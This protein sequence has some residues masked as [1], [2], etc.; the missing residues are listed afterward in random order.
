MRD[1][2]SALGLSTRLPKAHPLE[3]SEE[4]QIRDGKWDFPKIVRDE[5]LSESARIYFSAVA[6]LSDAEIGEGVILPAPSKSVP[7]VNGAVEAVSKKTGHRFMWRKA[8]RD[9]EE[10]NFWQRV[11]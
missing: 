7:L 10:V 8:D 6:M 11:R 5:P 9:G 1:I 3:T 4:G 2:L